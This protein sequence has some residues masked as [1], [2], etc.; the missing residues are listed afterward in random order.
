MYPSA[1]SGRK[2]TRRLSSAVRDGFLWVTMDG[3]VEK[4]W[5][6]PEARVGPGV[7][8]VSGEARA[9]AASE[10]ATYGQEKAVHK[11]LTEAGYYITSSRR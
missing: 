9:W 1:V 4:K 8:A 2:A 5:R 10:G 6:L 11:A 7:R 3:A